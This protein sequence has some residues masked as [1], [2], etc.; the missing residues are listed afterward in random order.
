MIGRDRE[1][2]ELDGALARTALGAAEIVVIAGEPGI[3]KTRLLLELGEL[4]PARGFAIGRGRA[5]EL[6]HE[7]PL[8]PFVE[9][10]AT[11]LAEL[12]DR[13]RAE[14]TARLPELFAAQ[15]A[16]GPRSPSP[17]PTQSDAGAARF[18][19]YRALTAL[20]EE[21][22]RRHPLV[23]I[24]DDIQWADPA[25]VEAIAHLLRH[26]PP[27]PVLVAL[28]HRSAG[29]PPMLAMALDSVAR[30]PYA[31]RQTLEPLDPDQ[32]AL[33]LADAP[34]SARASIVEDSG[35]NPFYLEQLLRARRSEPDGSP[36][37]RGVGEIEDAGTVPR[38]VVAAIAEEL[39]RLPDE[40]QLMLGAAAVA[41]EPFDLELAAAVAELPPDRALDLLDALVAGELVRPDP[42]S[43]RFR[44][45][46][47]LVRR[48]V[49]DWLP[50]SRRIRFH[51]GA[52][53][54]LA[55]RG[56]AAPAIARHVA[57]TARTGDSSAGELLAAAAREVLPEAPASA[58]RWLA[59][60]ISLLPDRDGP[61]RLALLGELAQAQ[62]AAGSL[63]EAHDTLLALLASAGESGIA[64]PPRAVAT[65]ASVCLALGRNVGVRERLERAVDELPPGDD[66]QEVPLLLALAM[67]AAFQGEFTRAE[68]AAQRAVAVAAGSPP[69]RRWPARCSR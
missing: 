23:L 45:R 21:I 49:Y 19:R 6:E 39:R 56:A 11:P 4:A 10:L 28:A 51:R 41:G 44:F 65:L 38:V 18:G 5:T 12:P 54:A 55:G 58:A 25:S 32:A 50:P 15:P 22:A 14:L 7:I 47:P 52:A 67:H 37:G 20:I 42:G 61:Q 26:P 3:G 59:L 60:A 24:I 46:H 68:D 40:A 31:T 13:D 48:A 66:E 53:A 34:E 57:V 30:E 9:A 33:L 16:A 64:E 69:G 29:M 8:G 17:G 36:L 35:G 63:R 27:A 1:L 2:A 43:P 62:A